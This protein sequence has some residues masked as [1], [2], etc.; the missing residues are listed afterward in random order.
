MGK[1]EVAPLRVALYV[2]V[3]GQEQA[4]KG[5][6]LEAQQESLEEYARERGWVIVGVYIDAAKTARKSLGKRTNFLRMLESVKQDNVDLILFTRL[7]RWFRSVADYYKV[8]E[9]LDAHNCG[10]LTTQEQYD[11]TTAGGRLY[12]NLR[13]SIAQNEADLCGERIG[14]VLDSK[15]KHGTVVSGKIPFGYRINE[16]KRLEVVPENAAIILDAFEHYRSTVSVRAT[17]AYIQRTYGLNWDN[18]RCRRNLVQ[19]LYIGHYE[20]NGRVNPNFCPPIVPRDLY[21]DV[22]KLLSNN[23]KANP[24]GRVFLF[25][26]LLICAECGHRLAGLQTGYGPYYRCPQHYSRRTCDHKKQIRETTI[27][28]WLFTFLGDELKKQR[29]EWDIKEARRRQTAAS[30]DRAA[31]RRKLSRLKELYVNE[32][33]D[34]EEYR[35]DYEL[36]TAQLAERTAPSAEEERPNFEAVEAILASGFRKIY[37]GLEREEKRTLWRSVIKEIRVDKERQITGIS[38][39]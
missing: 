38:F 26:S 34:L 2:R 32:M 8:M 35:W 4:I 7:D 19:T 30:I 3:S 9:I 22:Q 11:T 25:T 12:I 16:E 37:D 24:T 5:L 33:I 6:S 36:Y 27:E 21:D 10:W 31:I 1:N 15:V 13:L 17:A 23:T 20:S 39:L 28:E 29:L 18:V 14:V